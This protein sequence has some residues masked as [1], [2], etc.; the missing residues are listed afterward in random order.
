MLVKKCTHPNVT[1]KCA[2]KEWLFALDSIHAETGHSIRVCKA[3]GICE[4]EGENVRVE[5]WINK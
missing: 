2:Y 5:R 4:Y 1:V 3:K